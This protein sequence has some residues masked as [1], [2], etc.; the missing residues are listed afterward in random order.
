MTDPHPDPHPNPN[1]NPNSNP[2]PNL[3]P[4]PNPNPNPNLTPNPNANLNQVR[5]GG[6]DKG[7][8]CWVWNKL[9]AKACAEGA[10]CFYHEP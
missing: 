7:A 8:P 1:S 10:H 9:A 6:E 2:N 4:N 5:Y 3:N